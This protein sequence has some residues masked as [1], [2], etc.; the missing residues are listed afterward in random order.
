[1]QAIFIGGTGRSGTTIVGQLLGHHPAIV[2]T[3]PKEVRFITDPGGLLALLDTFEG[4]GD[5]T[6]SFTDFLESLRGRW[7][8][9]TGPDGGPRGL[10]RGVERH[11]FDAAVEDFARTFPTE[12]R[13][14]ARRL[15]RNL[16]DPMARRVD[17]KAWAETTPAN[18]GSADKL[19]ELIPDLKLIH[20]QRDPRDTIA[21]VLGQPWGPQTANE[22]IEWW[23]DSSKRARD[24][25]AR[26]PEGQVLSVLLEDLV[27]S[28]RND[29]YH[30][31]LSFVDVTDHP[32][33]RAFFDVHMTPEAAGIGRWEQLEPS[34]R[35]KLDSEFGS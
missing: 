26:I 6:E 1:M 10:H 13:V 8:Q 15:V 22:G 16:I 35:A 19:C 12:P 7:W 24:A 23:A 18:A 33:V 2:A 29:S 4:A 31:L 17:A 34:A 27:G 3:L 9:R 21:S 5:T 11:V 14:S 28:N 25:C 32:N 20:M 30:R